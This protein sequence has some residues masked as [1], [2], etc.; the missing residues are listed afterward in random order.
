LDP[1]LSLCLCLVSVR[2]AAAHLLYS[3]LTACHPP[4]WFFAVCDFATTPAF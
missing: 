4:L 3:L 2:T 1:S